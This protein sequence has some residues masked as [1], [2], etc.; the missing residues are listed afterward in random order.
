LLRACLWLTLLCSTPARASGADWVAMADTVFQHLTLEQGLP[1]PV[2]TTLAQTGDGFIWIGTENG[3]ARWD[4]YRFRIYTTDS[5]GSNS[6]P[7][8]GLV[9]LHTDRKG[10]LWCLFNNG[11]VARYDA[12]LDQ[13]ILAPLLT[14][15]QTLRVYT[16]IDGDG[17]DLLV[18][19]SGGLARVSANGSVVTWLHQRDEMG[20][21]V[22]AD[23]VLAL[24]R[25]TRGH[26]WIATGRG[27]WVHDGTVATPLPL[28]PGLSRI[29]TLKRLADGRILL[30]S[31]D[32]GVFM[33]D[34]TQRQ[35][36][37]V[38]ADAS[39]QALLA[40]HRFV[41]IVEVNPGEVWLGSYTQGI[42][43]L[44]LA[45]GRTE[46]LQ[47]DPTRASS[48]SGN[49]VQQLFIDRTGL[50][51]IA[52]Q[53]GVNLYDPGQRAVMT[54]FGG[55]GQ[56]N[57]IS[58]A[59]VRSLLVLDRD[60]ILLG[61]SGQGINLLDTAQRRVTPLVPELAQLMVQGMCQ[62]PGG[63][64][65][66]ATESGLV[67][68][69]Q[70]GQQV[71]RV[72]FS[73]KAVRVQ[74]GVAE[75]F[76][77]RLWVGSV[78]GLWQ[79]DPALP[80]PVL[81]RVPGSEAL[82]GATVRSMAWDGRHSLWLGTNSVG[83][84]HYDMAQ[85]RLTK[86]K[87][88]RTAGGSNFTFIATLWIDPQRRLWVGSQGDGIALLPDASQS[89]VAGVKILGKGDGLH[90]LM[91]NRFLPDQQGKL[92]ISTDDGLLRIDPVTLASHTLQRA[93][94]VHLGN[95]WAG[96]GAQAD[97]GVLL[98]GGAGGITV[99]RPDWLL[100]AQALPQLVISNVQIGAGEV[101]PGSG[102]ASGAAGGAGQVAPLVIPASANSIALE[103][104][105]LDYAAPER[106]AYRY[107]LEGYDAN[108]INTPATRRLA[109]YTNL[110]PGNYRLHVRASNR[111]GEWGRMEDSG[112]N[113]L[114]VP[115]QVLPH[116]WQTW[117]V[118]SI[119]ALVFGV[120][121]LS[122]VQGRTRWL[123]Q[124]KIELERLVD[125][126]TVALHHKQQELLAANDS[127]NLANADLAQ[128]MRDLQQAQ[129]QLLQHEKLASI[130]T[131]TAG[132][133]HEINNP[134][135]FAH[136]GAHNLHQDLAE[137]HTFLRHLAGDDAA[138]ELW[139]AIES[140][141]AKLQGSLDTV[142]EGTT[143]IRDLVRDL[144][145]FARLDEANWLVTPIGDG[146][147]AT[148]NL[149]RTQY[150]EQVQ[151]DLELAVDPPLSC[152]PTQL[153]QVFM[154]LIVNACQA[155]QS[156]TAE[157][158]AGRPGLLQIRSRIE[159]RTEGRT[160]GDY[161]LLEFADNGVGM[162]PEIIERIFDP[163]FTTKNVG[164]GMGMGLAISHGIIEKH[165]GTI[166]VTSTPG[167]GSCF[168]LR[169]PLASVA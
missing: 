55:P 168:V 126:R 34:P 119:L 148:V 99:L 57:H 138:P 156:R 53:R 121:V 82:A 69:D 79:L 132:I 157:Q 35:L 17:D 112:W 155:I 60:R 89:S 144:R 58:G 96:A 31:S 2:A 20:H 136:V 117:W 75:Y 59:D 122:L 137:L 7:D 102:E 8:P 127:L 95:Y 13:F 149:V 40:R 12:V 32:H 147:R 120:A 86:I 141:F 106:I 113:H 125:E 28:P 162:T 160:E 165:H 27:L 22:L 68:S 25:D 44:D 140:R 145:T 41:S 118:H 91:I 77:K 111:R 130:G 161:L 65:F 1:H 51:W 81:Q 83:L 42:V 103:F 61:L 84:Y 97:D 23:P 29:M 93:E 87:L 6:L 52:T 43:R 47:H 152:W 129:S 37:R 72:P 45:S 159:E 78:D 135:N 101:W 128:S 104:A 90:N 169:L 3:L 107:W 164:E 30:A 74:T 73:G 63:A 48:L 88:Q 109:S 139:Q 46:Q 133:S 9:H 62:V 158:S 151:I 154:N 26:L 105:A 98:F 150:T 85:Q 19:T 33:V 94:G 134:C 64:L 142:R 110:P 56:K 36:K 131:L 38:E 49:A 92:W 67:R 14:S 166:S 80:Q 163:F 167:Q 146:L 143:R 39:G 123:R 4:G 11:N 66:Y 54:L 70:A 15:S 153:N 76:A 71:Y 50:L 10:Q 114:I 124:R 21:D 18:G 115:L 116:W 108:W 16:M 24:E 100:S 5:G